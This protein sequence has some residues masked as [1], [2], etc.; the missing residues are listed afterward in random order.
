MIR[1]QQWLILEVIT[2]GFLLSVV[3]KGSLIYGFI[4]GSL[5]KC[6]FRRTG[7]ISGVWASLL[8]IFSKV[9]PHFFFP[10]FW[11]SISRLCFVSV[12]L[13]AHGLPPLQVCPH[14]SPPASLGL[15]GQT[16]SVSAFPPV[17]FLRGASRMNVQFTWRNLTLLIIVVATD[18]SFLTV[19]GD[20]FYPIPSIP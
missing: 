3:T 15:C 18:L 5:S 20:C 16:E 12:T 2:L 4:W 11:A 19:Y 8:L 14:A 9:S 7:W 10:M 6:S 1:P 17:R 13:V